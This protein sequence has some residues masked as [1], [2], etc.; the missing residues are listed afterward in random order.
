MNFC[1][2]NLKDL[3]EKNDKDISSLKKQIDDLQV[4][5]KTVEY[6]TSAQT[7]TYPQNDIDLNCG[8]CVAQYTSEEDLWVHM[9]NEHDVQKQDT[10][11]RL[12]CENCEGTFENNGDL[13]YHM[14]DRHEDF[15]EP[16]KF[17]ARGSCFFTDETCWYSHKVNSNINSSKI[18]LECKYCGET[19]HHKHELMRHRKQNHEDK[20]ALCSK[21]ESGKC[22]FEILCWFKHR[23]NNVDMSKED[24]INE[25]N[26][27]IIRILEERIMTM[28]NQI[29]MES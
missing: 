28:E 4:K 12:K 16:C 26:F 24:N 8:V 25:G 23:T 7:Q 5:Q 19:F 11:N 18:N 10:T 29:R 27:E 9:D 3:Q 22:D 2:K 13:K 14:K 21:Y 17:Y 1:K 15:L 20:V 6:M